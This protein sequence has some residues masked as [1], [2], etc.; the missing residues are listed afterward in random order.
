MHII[1]SS[2]LGR[3]TAF[4]APR[5]LLCL[6]SIIALS[7]LIIISVTFIV[8]IKQI[9]NKSGL[10]DKV[11]VLEKALVETKIKSS[12]FE[13]KVIHQEQFHIKL[14]T[15]IEQ[16][17]LNLT[18]Q[19]EAE[20]ER[21]LEGP[22]SELNR[23][24]KLMKSVLTSVGVTSV[25]THG[26]RNSGGPFVSFN[27][28]SYQDQIFIADSYLKTIRS[29]P[30]GFPVRGKITSPYG[31]RID[32]INGMP[33]FHAGIDITNRPGISIKAT[34]AGR[35]KRCGYDAG[36]GNFVLLDHGNGFATMYS[37]LQKITTAKGK[38]IERGDQIGLLGNSGRSTGPHL[39]YEIRHTNKT[40]NPFRY[41]QIAKLTSSK[42]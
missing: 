36:Y 24:N 23:R 16:D 12:I 42:R 31:R 22:V 28:S 8:A 13:N 7:V 35:I 11:A 18:A 30:L 26:K 41:M 39:H 20:K 25:S 14:L 1:I 5:R 9:H 37:H 4:S 38:R 27:D 32:P 2:D 29:V 3:T 6:G 15:E 21:L 40:V 34:A 17:K 33:A 10:E 19:Y